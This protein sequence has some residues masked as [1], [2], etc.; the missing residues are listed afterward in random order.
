MECRRS[1]R[2][3]HLFQRTHTRAK[4]HVR[5]SGFVVYNSCRDKCSSLLSLSSLALLSRDGP[6]CSMTSSLDH[7]DR[8]RSLNTTVPC[9]QCSAS[10]GLH[11][12]KQQSPQRVMWM[13]CGV[14]H[15]DV[16]GDVEERAGRTS[17]QPCLQEILLSAWCYEFLLRSISVLLSRY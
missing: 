17:F 1:E 8:L 7:I 10:G 13:D 9:P 16:E 5:Y 4:A 11:P 3:G 14:I 12:E 15:R 2:C 6:Q